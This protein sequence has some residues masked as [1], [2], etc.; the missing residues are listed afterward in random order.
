MYKFH[1]IIFFL[2]TEEGNK[3]TYSQSSIFSAK[4]S[5]I[6]GTLDLEVEKKDDYIQFTNKEENIEIFKTL[7]EGDYTLNICD[8][9]ECINYSLY[10]IQDEED[11][12]LSKTEISPTSI[13]G[14]SGNTYDVLIILKT[15]ERLMNY[16]ADI[17]KF[18]ISNSYG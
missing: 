11:F 8:D 10:L 5:G 1:Y 9:R 3:R 16:R 2:Y 15:K 13:Y 14:L 7:E 4:I 17:S 18:S 12:D 6:E